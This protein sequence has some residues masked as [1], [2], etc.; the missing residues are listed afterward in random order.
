V[1]ALAASVVRLEVA[2]AR[3]GPTRGKVLACVEV[4]LDDAPTPGGSSERQYA[5]ATA[6]RAP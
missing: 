4:V 1:N 3:D 6:G 5:R 2:D